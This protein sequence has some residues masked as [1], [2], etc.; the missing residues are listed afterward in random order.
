MQRGDPENQKQHV[1]KSVA[2][3]WRGQQK[4]EL[5]RDMADDL[6]YGQVVIFEAIV[7]MRLRQDG[8]KPDQADAAQE[9]CRWDGHRNGPGMRVEQENSRAERIASDLGRQ[10][11]PAQRQA[12][13]QRLRRRRRICAVQFSRNWIRE[14]GR[15]VVHGFAVGWNSA[16]I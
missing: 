4:S 8:K 12:A 5:D 3:L 11:L 1:Q 14:R 2:D 15:N 9:E 6:K 7:E 10:L 16:R 13:R